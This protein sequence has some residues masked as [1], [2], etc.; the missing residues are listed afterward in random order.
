MAAD[1]EKEKIRR[2]SKSANTGP[3]GTTRFRRSGPEPRTTR[4]RPASAALFDA[5]KY[6]NTY[7][8]TEMAFP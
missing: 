5:G 1:W 6:R 7:R 8:L 2:E 4:R 3:S